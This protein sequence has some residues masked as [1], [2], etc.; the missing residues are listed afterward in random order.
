MGRPFI[1]ADLIQ[2]NILPIACSISAAAGKELPDAPV[3]IDTPARLSGALK[4]SSRRVWVDLK[5]CLLFQENTCFIVLFAGI[6][7]RIM[8]KKGEMSGRSPACND[9][10]T[11]E[12]KKTK[13]PCR[14]ARR[15][16]PARR[17]VISSAKRST[18]DEMR[19]PY[20]RPKN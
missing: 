17:R 4:R 12:K 16:L 18:T 3:S 20:H 10:P 19:M 9:R 8:S 2:G 13:W 15:R 1:I 7:L 6:L 5:Y 14:D 11:A